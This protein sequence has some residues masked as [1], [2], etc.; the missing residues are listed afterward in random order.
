MRLVSD[1]IVIRGP[2]N[3]VETAKEH[4]LKLA[5]DKELSSF[6]ADIKAKAEFHRFLIGRG[7]STIR[8]V[9]FILI[10]MQRNQSL[11]RFVIFDN[12]TVF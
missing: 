2:K 10:Q 12:E 6:A 9:M 4:L 8:K 7:G 3:D 11:L 1:K 5:K